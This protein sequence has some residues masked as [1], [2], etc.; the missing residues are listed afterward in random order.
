MPPNFPDEAIL[1][2]CVMTEL[3]YNFLGKNY[4]TVLMK[5]MCFEGYFTTI[6]LNTGQHSKMATCSS[7]YS[8]LSAKE[9]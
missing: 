6:S 8:K 1:K 5:S 3:L 2:V 7:T 4:Y 9:S